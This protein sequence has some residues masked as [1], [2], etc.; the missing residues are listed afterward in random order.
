M[1]AYFWGANTKGNRAIAH[2]VVA[3]EDE[4]YSEG[5]KDRD[6]VDEAKAF[7][8]VLVDVERESVVV[9]AVGH[10]PAGVA[11]AK[12]RSRRKACRQPAA[13]SEFNLSRG[14]RCVALFGS[15]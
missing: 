4:P 14:S 10:D 5:E 3:L 2:G 15:R 9:I 11:R 8:V 13:G 1:N 12:R 7:V 6:R